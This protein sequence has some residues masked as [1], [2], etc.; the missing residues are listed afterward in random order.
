MIFSAGGNF[1]EFFLRLA[2]KDP[3]GPDGLGPA[4]WVFWLFI[5][6]VCAVLT[7]IRIAMRDGSDDKE[8]E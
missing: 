3:S 2:L 5:L 4:G 6:L 8:A 7:I 1:F